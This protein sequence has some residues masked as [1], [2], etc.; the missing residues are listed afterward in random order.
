[1]NINGVLFHSLMVA[2]FFTLPP[3]HF[4]LASAN[5]T[6]SMEYRGRLLKSAP[7]VFLN[8]EPAYVEFGEVQVR[9]LN[10][11]NSKYMRNFSLGMECK[12]TQVAVTH[13]GSMTAFNDAAVTTNI[14]GLGIELRIFNGQEEMVRFPVGDKVIYTSA[15]G[16]KTNL[17]LAALPFK[18]PGKKPSLGPFSAISTIQLEYP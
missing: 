6:G 18:D 16:A 4:S 12:E 1:M 17:I 8:N 9:D 3:L 14:D 11:K 10:D 15:G 13:L 7:C 5:T 2:I